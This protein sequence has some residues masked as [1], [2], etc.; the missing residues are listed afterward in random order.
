MSNWY[1]GLSVLHVS[2][3]CCV[4]S[5]PQWL[6]LA[7]FAAPCGC[8]AAG[9]RVYAAVTLPRHRRVHVDW[10]GRGHHKR[11]LQVA[12]RPGTVRWA[13]APR[14]WKGVT[15]FRFQLSIHPPPKP[16]RSTPEICRLTFETPMK[17]MLFRYTGVCWSPVPIAMTSKCMDTRYLCSL[18]ELF[19][20]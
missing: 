6:V 4:C 11:T 15:W 1:A 16:Q 5:E 9:A 13:W 8:R 14:T 3:Q 10:S 12:R 17:E 2:M 19:G 18:P 7:P 20:C